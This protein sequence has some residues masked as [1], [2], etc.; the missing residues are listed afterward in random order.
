[1]ISSSLSSSLDWEGIASAMHS[2]SLHHCRWIVK[3][4]SD[5][6]GVGHTLRRWGE[7]TSAQCPCCEHPDEDTSHVLR[8]HGLCSDAI[9]HHSLQHLAH[10]LWKARTDP[11]LI[12]T[13]VT[14]L[15]AW[16]HHSL[17]TCHSNNLLLQAA[18]RT[19]Q[20]I[21]WENCT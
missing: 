9:W 12:A 19:Q 8:C 13:I 17:P 10:C 2:V 18:F 21:R 11:E 5:Q 3:H 20:S 15:C 4:N 14:G 16:H 7:S 1:M 6:C